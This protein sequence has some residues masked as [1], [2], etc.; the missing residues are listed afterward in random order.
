[1]EQ[2]RLSVTLPFVHFS[3]WVSTTVITAAIVGKYWS[4]MQ[5]FRVS[6]H[7]RSM[8]LRS[9]L[10]WREVIKANALGAC[11]GGKPTSPFHPIDFQTIPLHWTC[12]EAPFANQQSDQRSISKAVR[13]GIPHADPPD[14]FV[15]ISPPSTPRFMEHLRV[16]LPLGSSSFHGQLAIHRATGDHNETPLNDEFRLEGPGSHF[17]HRRW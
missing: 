13:Y 4:W 12:P 8:G 14:P 2:R 15:R 5:S 1:M 6:F 3:N 11:F 7:T 10:Y 17:R 9:G 16:Y